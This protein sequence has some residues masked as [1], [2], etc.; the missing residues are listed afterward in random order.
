MKMARCPSEEGPEST[1]TF[2]V[3]IEFL[4]ALKANV[5]YYIPHV[6]IAH[7]LRERLGRFPFQVPEETSAATKVEADNKDDSIAGRGIDGDDVYWTVAAGGD[8]EPEHPEWFTY[9]TKGLPH[10]LGDWS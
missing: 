2:G 10:F 4:A 7:L 5:F 9:C 3:E 1:V 6:S 8:I